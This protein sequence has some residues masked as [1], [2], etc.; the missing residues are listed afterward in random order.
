VRKEQE[1]WHNSFEAKAEF[2]DMII[3]QRDMEWK[4]GAK[5]CCA[6]TPFLIEYA[7]KE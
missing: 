1:T 7:K 4:A 2:I 6:D 5:E 3:L